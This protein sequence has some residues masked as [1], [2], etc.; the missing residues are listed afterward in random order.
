MAEVNLSE[1][2]ARGLVIFHE[3]KFKFVTEDEWRKNG[4]LPE[5]T[6]AIKTLTDLKAVIARVETDVYVDLDRM[7]GLEDSNLKT[8]GTAVKAAAPTPSILL[9][10][11]G[12]LIRVPLSTFT[13]LDKGFEGDAGV[14]VNRGGLVAAIPR[15]SIPSGTYCVLVNLD[16]LK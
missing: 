16:M 5:P 2:G 13:E 14:I 6:G 15:N 10:E 9:R 12:D 7:D 11:R 1:I 3:K 8:E 4:K